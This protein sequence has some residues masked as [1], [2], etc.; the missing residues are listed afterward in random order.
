MNRAHFLGWL[1]CLCSIAGT[2]PSL[3]GEPFADCAQFYPW[4][5][6]GMERQALLCVTIKEAYGKKLNGIRFDMEGSNTA[7]PFQKVRLFSSGKKPYFSP[8]SKSLEEIH[9]VPRRNKSVFLFAK[10]IDL[11][12]N[13]WHHFWL[14]VDIPQNLRSNAIL[15]ARCTGVWV[16]GKE[17]PVKNAAPEGVTRL[18]PFAQRIVAYYRKEWLIRWNPKHLTHEHLKGLT[19]LIL[20]HISCQNNGDITGIEDEELIQSIAKSKKI[21][22]NL[23]VRLVIG[24]AHGREQIRS[25]VANQAARKHFA[26]QLAVFVKKY[27][28]DGF[29]IDWEYPNNAEDWSNMALLL[30]EVR[31]ALYDS[32]ATVCA[33]VTP[34]MRMPPPE[35][36]DQLDWV[37]T[38]SYDASGE[39]ST[40][41]TMRSD[42]A[43]CQRAGI[44][45][46]KIV[47]G[48]PFY[49]N[50]IKNRN[51]DAQKGYNYIINQHPHIKPSDT[52]FIDLKTH[53]KH[54]FN[55]V[56]LI[57]KKAREVRS[58][59]LGGVMVW[60]YETDIALKEPLSLTRALNSILKPEKR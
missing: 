19:D 53:K 58:R 29:E 44:P 28:L 11:I 43:A 55:G 36:F 2:S 50:E 25:M 48:L 56:D 38:M 12:D 45:L 15:D 54:Y 23:P 13:G 34:Y 4:F 10:D 20:F 18:H 39:H 27:K 51:W 40:M 37:N 22:G 1:L 49:S 7:R 5:Y 60:A 52:T 42:I 6:K 41:Q 30:S 31:P 9:C 17:V 35:V 3:R 26:R 24:M 47:V 33:A 16:D 14:V 8:H 21:R 59:A 32:G 46:K 57:T